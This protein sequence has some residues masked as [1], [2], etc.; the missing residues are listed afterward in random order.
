MRV[1]ITGAAG[2][3]GMAVASRLGRDHTVKGLDLVPGPCVDHVGNILDAALLDQLCNCVDAV[4]H[5]ASLHAPH[6]GR[7]DDALFRDVNVGGTAQLL[8]ACRR[9]GVQR[10]VYTSTTSVYGDAM[11]PQNR[12]VWVTETLQPKPRDIY[13]ETKLAAESLCARFAQD[14]GTCIALRMSRCFPESHRLMAVYRLYRGVDRQ[15][16]AEAHALAVDATLSGFHIFNISAPS[17]FLPSDTLELYA[18][19]ARTIRRHYPW[20]PAEFRRRNWRLPAS[21][22]R[23]YAIDKAVEQLGYRPRYDFATLFDGTS[24][25]SADP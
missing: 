21:I 13:D 16:V 24:D 12:A 8:D 15:D 25:A 1:L 7:V 4:V 6:V 11:V 19:A 9:H 20:A 17:R 18:D 14:T 10:F 23:V 22:D 5:T 2:R 3:I